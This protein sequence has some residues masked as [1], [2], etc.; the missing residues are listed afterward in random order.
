MSIA[1]ARCLTPYGN[2]TEPEKAAAAYVKAVPLHKGKEKLM[3]AIFRN[4]R[5]RSLSCS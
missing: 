2:R 3:A 1:P 4:S 5:Q